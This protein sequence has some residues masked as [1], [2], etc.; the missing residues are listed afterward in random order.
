MKTGTL[1][2]EAVFRRTIAKAVLL[3]ASPVLLVLYLLTALSWILLCFTMLVLFLLPLLALKYLLNLA[4]RLRK[5]FLGR[6]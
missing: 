6:K 2:I 3:A 4:Q 5:K 1:K